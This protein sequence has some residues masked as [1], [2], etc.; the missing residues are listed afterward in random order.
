MLYFVLPYRNPVRYE[1]V[2]WVGVWTSALVIPL[3]LVCG[4]VR[5]I[6]LYWR[7]VD[8]AFGVFCAPVLWWAIGWVREVRSARVLPRDVGE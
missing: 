8:R 4:A 1:G 5:E 7:L 2:L 6:P 3:A